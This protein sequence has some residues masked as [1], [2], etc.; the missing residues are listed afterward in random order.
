MKKALGFENGV[1]TNL[2][3][4]LAL[5]DA[6]ET[7]QW[8]DIVDLARDLDKAGTGIQVLADWVLV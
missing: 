8:F 3:D 4:N 1:F 6:T 5:P 7:L 2:A